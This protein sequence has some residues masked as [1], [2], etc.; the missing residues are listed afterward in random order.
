[1]IFVR[2]TN[3]NSKESLLFEAGGKPSTWFPPG[4]LVEP[5]PRNN[6]A[7]FEFL[8]ILYKKIENLENFRNFHQN[9]N[10]LDKLPGNCPAHFARA[11][12]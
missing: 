5:T 1:M 2:K 8:F 7:P 6:W 4:G 3:R 12:E 10:F 11:N 9:I